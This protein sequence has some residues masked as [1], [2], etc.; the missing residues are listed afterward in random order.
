MQG[1]I[2]DRLTYYKLTENY[3]PKS[4]GQYFIINYR[5]KTTTS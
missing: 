4:T 2:C 3:Q 5:L 1:E